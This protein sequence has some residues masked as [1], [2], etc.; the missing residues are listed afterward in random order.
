MKISILDC[1]LRDG[2]YINDWKFGEDAIIDIVHGIES[3]GI[4]ILE[5]GFIKDE[6]YN[7][8]RTVFNSMD[9]VKKLIHRKANGVKYAVMAEVVNPLP[10]E[11]LAPADEEGP[12]IIRVIVWKRML[13]EGFEYCKGIV[14]KGYKLCVQPARVSQYS[15]DE[16]IE[17]IELFNQLEP[18]A[19]YVV[20]SWGTMYADALL[21][22]MKLADEHLKPGIAVGYHGHNNM[23]QAFDVACAFVR[24]ETARDVIIDASIYGIGRG[25]GNLNLELVAKYLNENMGKQYV[26]EPMLQIYDR[27]IDSIYNQTKWGFSLPYFV[28]AKYN[29]NPGYVTFYTE[30]LGLSSE[31]IEG[32]IKELDADERIIYSQKNADRALYRSRKKYCSLC[33]VVPTHHRPECVRL[34]LETKAE[35]Y[36]QYGVDILFVGGKDDFETEK[37]IDKFGFENVFCDKYVENTLYPD[38]LDEKIYYSMSVAAKKYDAIWLCRD[39]SLPNIEL[40]Y[41]SIIKSYEKKNDFMVLFPHVTEENVFFCETIEDRKKLLQE[42]FGNMTSLGSILFFL[43]MAINLLEKF[44]V[45]ENS[46]VGLWIPDVIFHEIADRAFKATYIN[47]NVFTIVPYIE[48][49][50]WLKNK[51]AM[52]MWT[53]RWPKIVESLPDVYENIKNDVLCFA[54]WTLNPFDFGLLLHSKASGDFTFSEVLK[55]RKILKKISGTRFRDI[56]FVSLM[57][58]NFAKAYLADKKIP[59]VRFIRFIKREIVDRFISLLSKRKLPDCYDS[60][61]L[62]QE[63][64]FERNR[65]TRSLLLFGSDSSEKPWLTIVIPTNKRPD[66]LRDALW[67]V[68]R[69]E[70]AN[71]PWELIVVDNEPYD[72]KINPTQR[73]VESSN[74]PNVKYY[75]NEKNLGVCGNMN[76]GVELAKGEW[77]TIL[78]D[79]DLLLRTYLVEIEKII[80][81]LKDRNSRP[82]GMISG[83]HQTFSLPPFSKIYDLTSFYFMQEYVAV[84]RLC[85]SQIFRITHANLLYT[86]GIGICAPT[87]GNVYNKKVFMD[88]GGFDEDKSIIADQIFSLNLMY[89]SNVYLVADA[90]G[91][92][93]NYENTTSKNIKNIII[94]MRKLRICNYRK[95]IWNRIMELITEKYF[96]NADFQYFFVTFR[97]NIREIK[98]ISELYKDVKKANYIQTKL[99]KLIIYWYYR[100]KIE[101]ISRDV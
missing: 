36:Y 17:M 66:M 93:R 6:P 50:F 72:G 52:R 27:Y 76:R 31:E 65:K 34:W 55:N 98:I 18:M 92:Y 49:S 46:N 54:N 4:E 68:L 53:E 51:S 67:S 38:T 12:E 7:K 10:L 45:K 79:D 74:I 101:K 39:R 70:K 86:G 21:H 9:Q 14:E 24:Q 71:Y 28:S 69:Q 95:S 87:A 5:L 58:E 91:F 19:V 33:I 60:K 3:T 25:A 64:C 15:D 89:R 22:Y 90:L 43:N 16:F 82:L 83:R 77:V 26:L 100:W 40:V 56:V 62:D 47:A 44:P 80:N 81:Q 13:K 32:A 97:N 94:D 84:N 61:Y 57:T 29:C 88:T 48:T 96:I 78:H 8:D 37:I 23:M 99:S 11:K 30:K 59:R 42:Y 2:G 85:K 35:K 63:D 75:R 73:L 20:D 1:T 41:K